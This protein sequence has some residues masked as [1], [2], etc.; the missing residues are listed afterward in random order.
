MAKK[1]VQQIEIDV[2]A[3]GLAN[4]QKQFEELAKEQNL[5]GEKSQKV[6]KYIEKINSITKEYGE[7]M[8][9]SKAKEVAEYFGRIAKNAEEISEMDT[10]NILSDKD[11]E[12]LS[13]INERIKELN[14]QLNELKKNGSANIQSNFKSRVEELKNQQTA[15]NQDGKSVKLDTIKGKWN[16]YED[17]ET[18]SK[19]SNIKEQQAALAVMY[20]WDEAAKKLT[21]DQEALN[22]Q[23]SQLS[24]KLKD[25]KD[26]GK[27]IT[28]T[29]K[30]VSNEQ[31]TAA[32]SAAIFA[33]AQQQAFQETI[34][35]S[36]EAG[37]D[38][39]QLTN[40]L[41]KQQGSLG[42]VVKSLFSFASA[43]RLTKKLLSEAVK[44]VKE[45]DSAL[46]GMAMVTGK[47]NEE[48]EALIPRIQELSKN[49]ST[50][51]TDVANLIT[52]YT[53]QGRSLEE[54]FTLAEET[55][56]AAKI[57]GISAAESIEYMTA[58]IN[59]FNLAA[60][61]AV[62]VS[63]IF[64]N[65]AAV[66][67]TDYEQLAVALSK[68]SAQA[69]LAGL[70]IEYTTALLAKGIETTQ[71]A[72]ESIGTALKTI[73]ARMRELSDYGSTLEDGG[74]VNGVEEALAA[75]GIELRNVN[76]EFRDLEDIFNELG[77]KWDTLNT[78]Q[79]QAIA[80]AV[81]GTR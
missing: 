33:N 61:D 25:Y 38:T 39:V 77:P 15:R 58:A 4:T 51:M 50:A 6:L 81:A 48:T 20:Q 41:G 11:A 36:Q 44:T 78:M 18:L 5:M 46:N 47:T 8:P 42:G 40:S 72:P 10:V 49:T 23:I 55:A 3:K 56:K 12:R 79:Q 80:Q 65:V 32:E 28:S 2:V 14:R 9:I 24:S 75:A 69:N 35:V 66:S 45:M 30:K 59:G 73:L 57:S 43:W 54:S 26:Q 53:K 71:E 74:T 22:K 27:A 64:A 13:T 62:E 37:S 68:V 63:D 76:G 7:N 34:I 21:T 60:S 52:E 16:S 29:L 70:T 19:S 1:Q 31:K 67:A 17:L